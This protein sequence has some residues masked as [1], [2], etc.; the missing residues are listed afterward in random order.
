[1]TDAIRRIDVFRA[2]EPDAGPDRD[3]VAVEEPLEV[4]L[5]GPVC[6]DQRT[7][8]EDGDLAA[9]FLFSEGVLRSGRDVRLVELT[10]ANRVN[11]RLSRSRAEILPD[12]L[13]DRVPS[14]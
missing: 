5:E 3:A 7:P 1:M 8:G 4:A 11:V 10:A 9:G 12:L 6:G 2:F 13:A 14:R